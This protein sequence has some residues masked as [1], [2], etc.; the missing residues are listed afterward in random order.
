MRCHVRNYFKFFGYGEQDFVPCEICG[1]R[2]VDIHHLTY[3]S[4]GGDDTVNNCMALCRYHHDMVHDEQISEED[5]RI[6]HDNFI[7]DYGKF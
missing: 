5:L 3:R 1:S 6:V 2:A 7:V 4:H